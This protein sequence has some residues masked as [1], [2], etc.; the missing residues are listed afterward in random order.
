M[1]KVISFIILALSLKVSAFPQAPSN[2]ILPRQSSSLSWGSCV[3]DD[4]W[5]LSLPNPPWGSPSCANFTVPL[6]WTNASDSRTAR[7]YVQKIPARKGFAVGTIFTNPGGPGGPGSAFLSTGTASILY[8]MTEGM[9][10]IISWDP[11]G[12][13]LSSPS[14]NCFR[15]SEN[16]SFTQDLTNYYTDL[17]YRT[18]QAPSSGP[19][20][21]DIDRLLNNATQ[22][23]GL[24]KSV[25]QTCIDNNGDEMKYIGTVATVRDLVA[26][27]DTIDGPGS[28]INYWGFSY[29]SVL[30]S[31][32]MDLYPGRVGRF[33]LDGIWDARSYSQKDPY[34]AYPDNIQN[35]TKALQAFY[36]ACA[37]VLNEVVRVTREVSNVHGPLALIE[38]PAFYCHLWPFRAVE[39]HQTPDLAPELANSVLVIGNTYDVITP[40]SWAQKLVFRLN[41]NKRQAALVQHNGSGHPSW[42]TYS[43]CT[44]SIMQ[45]YFTNGKLPEDT[46]C[47]TETKGFFGIEGPSTTGTAST[48]A[49]STIL[50]ASSGPTSK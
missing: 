11:R 41:S 30:G 14:I 8:N 26:L 43:S 44:W 25:F 15:A 34:K 40:L 3:T 50:S 13:G 23:E 27:A 29:G 37:N 38:F 39:R 12:V 17:L 20:Q 42:E 16:T 45:N 35:A 19:N 6:D 31:T 32:L 33:V 10:D 7:L 46:F 9:F 24:L 2:E 18:L 36:D 49:T 47:E 1:Q 22:I 5:S 48:T 21:A 4:E 28:S